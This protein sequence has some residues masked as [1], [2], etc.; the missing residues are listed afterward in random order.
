MKSFLLRHT[1]AAF[2]AALFLLAV[3]AVALAPWWIDTRPVRVRIEA[4]ASSALGG[5]VTYG[6]LDL[7]WFPRTEA[8]LRSAKVSVPRTVHGTV[9]S[10][11]VAFALLPLLRGRFVPSGIAVDG[12]DAFISRPDGRGFWLEGVNAE[13]SFRSAEGRTEID[14]SRLSL[15]SP[16]LTGSGSFRWDPGTARADVSVRGS[17]DGDAVRARLLE[18]AG[19]DRTIA[20]IFAIFRGGRLAFSFESTARAPS[21]LFALEAMRVRAKVE[22]AGVRIDGPGLNLVD[23]SADVTLEGGVLS[24]ENAVARVG[25]S[26]ATGGR[27]LVG[28]APGDGRLH[29]E[30]DVRAD[31]AELP[32]ILARA[33]PSRSLR[34]ELALLDRLVG[35]A[36][37]R[38][39]IG[40]CAGNAGTTVDLSELRFDAAYR[41]LPWPVSVRAGRFFLD[42]AGLGV[43]GLTGTLGG[44][45]F[46]GLA[47][48]VRLGKRAALE[49]ASGSIVVSLEDF[50]EGA[51]SIQ[52]AASLVQGVR[53]LEGSV[54]IDLKRLAGPLDRLDEA[55]VSASGTFK[56]ILFS[57]SSSLSL[58]QLSVAS[59]RFTLSDDAIR[60]EDVDARAMDAALR[61][62]GALRG[63]RKGPLTVEAAAD[64]V[65]GAEAVPWIWARASLPVALLPDVPVALRGVRAGFAT[66]GALS[67]TGDL[68]VADGPLLKVD[69]AGD[70][71]TIEVR[72]LTVLDGDTRAS[73]AL[74]RP[75]GAYDA[76][77]RGTLDLATI[78][79]VL[80]RRPLR[81]G[82]IDGEIR[83]LVPAEGPDPLTAEGVLAARDVEVPTPAGPVTVE[84]LEARATG[85][86][87]DVLS[88][89]LAL[90]EQRFTISGSAT[91]EEKAVA[92][93]MDVGTGDLAWTRVEKVLGRG[94]TPSK[95]SSSDSL[96]IRG[97]LRVSLDSFAY[98]SFLFKPVLAD[99]RLGAESV[100]VHVRKADVCG[101]AMTGEARFLPGGA[102]AVEARVAASGDDVAVPLVCLGLEKSPFTGSFEANADVHGEGAVADIP[103]A[104]KGP[105]SFEAK[106]G[107]MGKAS[108]MSRVL[109]VLNATEVFAGK[110]GTRVGDAMPYSKLAVEGEIADGSLSIQA[111]TFVSPSVTAAAT[112]S[113]GFL[114][115]SLD[116][117]VLSHPLSTFD[118]IV[119]KIPVI[120]HILG[121]D[122]LAVGAKVTGTFAEPKVKVTPA[123]DIGKGVVGI[124]E[125]TVTLPVKVVDPTPAERK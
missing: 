12:L 91:V 5:A 105:V 115:S 30:A 83:V 100:A 69:L 55:S 7:A 73:F 86:R 47:A 117:V 120:R 107:R 98:G 14:L 20:Q 93:D 32:A 87:V 17:L 78:A 66:G 80:A 75:D 114:D 112:G 24:A 96:V 89:S 70:G 124:L 33:I 39:T 45:T 108:L 111:A 77:F 56:E 52:N 104:L 42:G 53:R 103:R 44:S 82:R 37:G 18:F 46:E 118:K 72:D 49:S 68:V 123:R 125:R 113:I 63:W 57:S 61:L 97:D 43:S 109:G 8:V 110:S 4:A 88:S 92:L 38:I 51:R 116:I 9:R 65:L 85:S 11:R 40:E 15:V 1:L 119:Q 67:L 19:D 10:V 59:G 48:R 50:L 26:R 101:I 74:A 3:A 102:A 60:I 58:P 27:L 36:A 22:D 106:N 121:R 94:G 64:G 81:R 13:G 29:V 6:K 2:A 35:R 41:R 28:L 99:V 95:K 71:T 34:Q 21:D 84:R 23:V 16:A 31:L 79:R 122:F 90:D 54:E 76:R 25:R 62:S